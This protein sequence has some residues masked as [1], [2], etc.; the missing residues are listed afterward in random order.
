MVSELQQNV[1]V[2]RT[3]WQIMGIKN[4][5]ERFIWFDSQVRKKKY[6]NTTSLAGQFEIS[7]KTAQRDIDFMRDRLLCPMEYE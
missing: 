2:I 1:L 4:I 5:Y 7:S 3:D 6:P